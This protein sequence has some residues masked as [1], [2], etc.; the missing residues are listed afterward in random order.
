MSWVDGLRHRLYVLFNAAAYSREQ[1]EER[2]FHRDMELMNMA[3]EGKPLRRQTLL[4]G[5]STIALS[6]RERSMSTRLLDGLRQDLHYATRGLIRSPAFALMAV[7]TLALGVGANAAVFSVLDQLFGQPPAGVGQPDSLRR[8]YIQM[9]HHPLNPG[10]V[11]P[12]FN[13]P[14]FS[15]VDDALGSQGQLAAWTPSAEHTLGEENGELPV[16]VSWVTHDYFR[17][18]QVEAA[19][20]RLFGEEEARV[21]VAVP[22][23]VISHAF[24]ERA[25]PSAPDVL[26]RSL[27]LDGTK[28][29]VIGVTTEGFTGLDLNYTDVFL[30]LGTF[31]AQGQ[32]GLPW[33]EFIGNYLQAVARL[34]EGHADEQLAARATAGYHR[35]VLPPQGGTPDS[36]NVVVP[37]SI[38][39]ARG[40]GASAG[41]AHENQAVS[42]S[43]R[44][45]GV[46]LIVLLIAGANVGGLL[47]VRAARRRHEIAVRRA[48][49]ISRARL[50]SQ[51][52]TEGLVLTALAAVAAVPLAAWGGTVL[53]RLLLPDI[54]WA[55]D[56][57]D[58]R[59][60]MFALASATVVG[61]LAALMPALQSWGGA[62]GRSLSVTSREGGRR[63]AALRSGLLAGQ[64]A[65]AVILLMGAGLFV[66]SLGNVS[67]L[68]LGF[69]V[70]ELAWVS[71][72][73]PSGAG[74]PERLEEVASRLA[75]MGVSGTALARV[76]PM[77]GSSL[78]RVFLPG[79]DSLPAFDPAAYPAYNTVSPEFFAV[80]GMRMLEGRAFAEGERD[81]V[82]VSETMARMFWPQE[83]AVGKCIVL[84]E[85]G[86][87]CQQVIGVAEDSRRRAIIEEPT[88]H[89][90]LPREA[91]AV[92]GVILMRVDS[93]RWKALG[94]AIRAELSGRYRPRDVTI[95]RMSEA[96][97]P[98][99]R[100]W[101]L[102]AQLFTGFGLLAL[103]VT[104]IGVYSVMAY[105][106]SQR[107]H[108]MGVRMALGARTLDILGLIIASGLR[109]VAIGVAIGI[110][111][112]LALGRIVESLLYNVTPYDPVALIWA[113]GVLLVT[114][115][116]ASLVPAWRAGRLDPAQTLRPD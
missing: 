116:T 71:L 38:I 84:G 56:A 62:V 108:E 89:Y 46:S 99:F 93:R 95:R 30:P 22:V 52:L 42:L 67:D 48:L 40:I 96:L 4:H 105:A 31:P 61:L 107:T 74:A 64:A 75:G 34:P 14:A 16:R 82:V 100:P 98:Q 102:G 114:G 85:P 55:R 111:V 91:D 53:R 49:G 1:A 51:F 69:D 20:G 29:T 17:V 27:E 80:A 12:H 77:M 15:A 3:P 23:A 101:R 59:A 45:A 21:N 2:R 11:F 39:A 90:F 79:R 7:L 32:L 109:V 37:G 110:A 10:M 19:S 97:E 83:S 47:L 106:V 18:L 92:G 94:D 36:T 35:Q 73:N 25:F 63:G 26:G 60:I 43:K 66:R 50:V 86:A 68:R 57:L 9:P 24:R 115:V 33:Y 5:S 103:I 58:V 104:V 88:L 28:Y 78:M 13:Y 70:D 8:L 65:L 76:P 113:A 81:V 41:T 54:H 87:E 44:M 72:R 112:S 6:D